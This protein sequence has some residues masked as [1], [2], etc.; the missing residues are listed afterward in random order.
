MLP[1]VDVIIVNGNAGLQ[2]LECV[3][4]F[5]AVARDQVTLG[6][7]VVVDN[8]STDGSLK[9]LDDIFGKFP[10]KLI[11][12]IE[13]RGF[14]AACN[15]GA[16]GSTADFL[17]FLNPDT[18]LNAGCF[19]KPVGFFAATGSQCVGIVGVQLINA[20]GEVAHNC[21]RRPT[22]AAMIGQTLGLDRL[23]PSY[24]PPHFLS[25]WPHDA[26]RIVDQVMGA[27]CMIRRPLFE[28]LRGF[29]ERF[30]VYFEDLDLALRARALGWT[31]VYLVTAQA[32]HR[33]QG[34]TDAAKAHRLYYFCRSRILF[35]FKHF[36][37]T[38]AIAVAATTLLI[39]PITR[40]V[41]AVMRGRGAE[42]PDILRGFAAL[43]GD[44][45]NVCMRVVRPP[46]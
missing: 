25:E 24:F 28:S 22:A 45:P 33:G 38:A 23:L 2:L 46:C 43:W 13:N 16:A 3:E 8:G 14:A 27:F 39:E 42:V 31:S 10:L 12:N 5:A 9:P 30:F 41:G 32:F 17:L 6:S 15:Q 20:V 44:L 34:T 7:I 4:S 36:T 40:T 26:T 11:R 1:R 37:R 19:K 29:D 35:A 18:R 21:T